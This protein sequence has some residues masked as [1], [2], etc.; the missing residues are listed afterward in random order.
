[1]AHHH[2]RRGAENSVE[3]RST[4]KFILRYGSLALHLS[5]LSSRE[6]LVCTRTEGLGW[7]G[8]GASSPIERCGHIATTSSDK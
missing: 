3:V 5:C 6:R 2:L 4:E 1:M 8:Y 7:L